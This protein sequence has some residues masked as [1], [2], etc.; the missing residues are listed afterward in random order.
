MAPISI[1]KM[2]PVELKA[3][4]PPKISNEIRADSL[5]A[6]TIRKKLRTIANKKLNIGFGILFRNGIK[7]GDNPISKSTKT[8]NE[9]LPRNRIFNLLN[10]QMQVEEKRTNAKVPKFR[11]ITLWRRSI[12]ANSLSK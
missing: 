4:E 9:R 1:R 6:P 7:Q 12:S 11:L 2:I 8:N 10:I 3:I 5:D